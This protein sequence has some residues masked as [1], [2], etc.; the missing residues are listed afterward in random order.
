[1]EFTDEI[2]AYHRVSSMNRTSER[3]ISYSIRNNY[4][5]IMTYFSPKYQKMLIRRDR[6]T[7]FIRAFLCKSVDAFREGIRMTEGME[8]V[9]YPVPEDIQKFYID[10]QRIFETPIK[11]IIRKIK[12]NKLF[13]VS[14]NV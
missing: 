12:Y 5:Y 1:M 7:W 6:F 14:K 13:F 3:L 8:I 2:T 10:N 4:R 9:T 11:K